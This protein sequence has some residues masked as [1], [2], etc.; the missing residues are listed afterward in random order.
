MSHLGK[1]LAMA[2]VIGVGVITCW[3]AGRALWL[4][5]S[6][7]LSSLSSQSEEETGGIS[8]ISSPGD[9]PFSWVADSSNEQPHLSLVQHQ[10]I[11]AAD[12]SSANT[13]ALSTT[14]PTASVTTPHETARTI[15]NNTRQP[16]RG[17]ESSEEVHLEAPQE[18][19]AAQFSPTSD[20]MPS[21]PR[22][23][24]DPKSED[25]RYQRRDGKLLNSPR[26]SPDI[27]ADL[28]ATPH[29]T[30]M[31]QPEQ[32]EVDDPF[33]GSSSD[34]W[35]SETAQLDRKTTSSDE[36]RHPVASEGLISVENT[37]IEESTEHK[38]PFLPASPEQNPSTGRSMPPD[39]VT[40]NPLADPFKLDGES[41]H[42]PSPS[43]QSERTVP[44]GRRT[45]GALTLPPRNTLPTPPPIDNTI[46]IRARGQQ[47]GTTPHSHGDDAAAPSP[48]PISAPS[49]PKTSPS[50]LPTSPSQVELNHDEERASLPRH[51]PL[52]PLTD[53]TLADDLDVIQGVK[54]EPFPPAP[55]SELPKLPN[56][57]DGLPR[58][59]GI[60]A[61]SIPLQDLS[62]TDPD[63]S[64]TPSSLPK[65]PDNP[66][67]RSPAA[68]FTSQQSSDMP[69]HEML[70]G[71]G[72]ADAT[73]PRG[74]LEPRLTIQK[75]APPQ[76]FVGQELVYAIV[77][78]NSGDVPA[79]QV[80][81]EDRIPRGARLV[82]TA[83]RAE[84]SDKRLIWR[85]GTLA[86][87]EERKIA[88]KVIPEQEGPL[89]SVAKVNFVSEIAAE[90]EV[91][92]P[93]LKLQI[94]APAEVRLGEK[95]QV[96]FTISN[97]GT[98]EAREVTLRTVFDEKLYHPAGSDLEYPVGALAPRESRQVPLE[99]QTRSLGSSP[100]KAS[101]V[102][103]GDIR[104]EAET[105]L[106][107]AGEY[108][109]ITRLGPEKVIVDRPTSFTN[110]VTNEGTRG[111]ERV[112]LIEQLPPG[113]D[114]VS[115]EP[116]GAFDARNRT[117][118]WNLPMLAAGDSQRI[119]LTVTPRQAGQAEGELRATG[120]GGQV[121]SVKTVFQAEGI[122]AL[123][124]HSIGEI[125]AVQAGEQATLQ[126]QIK[127]RGSAPAEKV[128]L[129]V[130]L[131]AEVQLISAQGPAA[132]ELIGQQLV[133]VPLTSLPP[134]DNATYS[135][136]L[137][138]LQ[139][140]EARLELLI[141][142]EHL[143]RPVRQEEVLQIVGSTQ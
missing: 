122:P 109:V 35:S 124:L 74:S 37:S 131:P 22:L 44:A 45:S 34:A 95:I 93:Q 140:G 27:P 38:D 57:N 59:W 83:P 125:P 62:R 40:S 23:V 19:S 72:I 7:Q 106:T 105:S 94:S 135:L 123:T 77:V 141:H 120:A 12:S 87:H 133:F 33:T 13:P 114:Y 54:R 31:E 55:S 10:L 121:S 78:K 115:S 136:T 42:L 8:E 4:K 36:N 26:S 29:P 73:V 75:I 53:A 16:Y 67:P 43:S 24:K 96:L 70:K 28:L 63:S 9:A 90:I 134:R 81:V 14:S 126:I 98:G 32:P 139:P 92:A 21:A 118:L 128:G 79:S 66:P 113:I 61:N 49:S 112:R 111:A 85:I 142:A 60:Q 17:D 15:F 103:L 130:M 51:P 107:I 88:V 127:N 11:E 58:R 101:V 110:I 2:G 108:L 89:G 20:E 25:L 104:A 132:Y 6:Q 47:D 82:G 18:L 68:P 138:A 56:N 52:K 41:K 116:A 48:H 91:K 100:I 65:L 30:F 129:S 102:S 84:L 69:A 117:V 143:K 5:Q 137:K 97:T 86:P 39:S 46:P 80:V 3:Q 99:I 1:I 71:D 119:T 64:S 76:A 50:H